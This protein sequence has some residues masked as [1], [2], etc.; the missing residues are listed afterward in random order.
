MTPEKLI[1]YLF[2]QRVSEFD[3]EIFFVSSCQSNPYKGGL[4]IGGVKG[5][6]TV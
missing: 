1:D 2:I 5:T 3:S 4:V 6:S